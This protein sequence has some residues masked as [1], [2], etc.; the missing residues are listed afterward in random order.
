MSWVDEEMKG[1]Y[2]KDKRIK[3]HVT[4]VLDSIAKSSR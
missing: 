3:A 1:L 4:K 2:V